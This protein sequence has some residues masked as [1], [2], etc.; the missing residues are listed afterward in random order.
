MSNDSYSS[1]ANLLRLNLDI[2]LVVNKKP[3]ISYLIDLV[4]N[5]RVLCN[6]GVDDR[7]KTVSYSLYKSV[8]EISLIQ[9]SHLSTSN[10]LIF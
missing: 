7:D 1:Q 2:K 3:R 8:Y 4:K 6:D 9:C 5:T 10:Q